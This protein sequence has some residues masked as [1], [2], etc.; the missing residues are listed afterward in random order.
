MNH[1]DTKKSV[2]EE[3]GRGIDPPTPISPLLCLLSGLIR[4][5]STL[6]VFVIP[7]TKAQQAPEKLSLKSMVVHLCH[8]P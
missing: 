4:G 8:W 3:E 1:H 7:L 5:L 2:L 6:H